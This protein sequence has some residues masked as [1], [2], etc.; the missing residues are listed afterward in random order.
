MV[1]GYDF[2]DPRTSDE[3]ADIFWT[4]AGRWGE[5]KTFLLGLR[6]HV[7][8]PRAIHPDDFNGQ[9]KKV[10]ENLDVERKRWLSGEFPFPGIARCC[11]AFSE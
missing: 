5:L 11:S 4:A 1:K 9:V 8:S 6:K 3:L 10:F 2:N 7:Q